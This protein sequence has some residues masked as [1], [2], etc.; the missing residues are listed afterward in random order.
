MSNLPARRGMVAGSRCIGRSAAI[1]AGSSISAPGS[2]NSTRFPTNRRP[3]EDHAAPT[4]RGILDACSPI[5]ARSLAHGAD[6]L[7]SIRRR[8]A[9]SEAYW[10]Q[11]DI[12]GEQ[13]RVRASVR[14]EPR[15]AVAARAAA[16]RWWAWSSR[17]LRWNPSAWST[18]FPRG[19]VFSRDFDVY[20]ADGL[21]LFRGDFFKLTPAAARPRLRRLR[22][23]GADLL[24]AGTARRLCGPHRRP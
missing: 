1:A 23:R 13:P 17:P 19:A 10:P 8:P 20:E 22:S 21:T 24:G 5:L 14:Q 12:A 18:A 11:L 7:S 3:R 4:R 9:S 15:F 2:P 16:I 6:R